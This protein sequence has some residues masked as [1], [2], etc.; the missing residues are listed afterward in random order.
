[1]G[2]IEKDLEKH[3]TVLKVLPSGLQ[4]QTREDKTKNKKD[5]KIS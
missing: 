3:T 1:M 2:Q 4:S 5:E